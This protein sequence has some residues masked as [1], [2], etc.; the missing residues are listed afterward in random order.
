MV[1]NKEKKDAIDIASM[2][3]QIIFRD[4]DN[5]NNNIYLNVS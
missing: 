1:I 3:M 4:Y 5:F 2:V